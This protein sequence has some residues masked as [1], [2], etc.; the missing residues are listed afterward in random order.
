MRLSPVIEKEARLSLDKPWVEFAHDETAHAWLLE[1]VIDD[2]IHKCRWFAGKARKISFI[3]IQQLLTIAVEGS[4]AYLVIL[5]IGYTYGDEEKYA[6]PV[7]FL[8]DDYP[9]IE[10]INHKAFIVRTV[11]DGVSGWLIDAIYDFRFQA[12]L[13]NNIWNNAA[14]KQEVGQISYHRGSGLA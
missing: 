2:Y 4:Q 8:P 5:H 9:L 13:F 7:A 14:D 11:A 10:Q 6:M 12:Q 1:H 3:K